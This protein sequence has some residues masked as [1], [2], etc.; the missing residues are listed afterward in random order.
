MGPNAREMEAAAVAVAL[1]AAANETAAACNGGRRG[2]GY[3]SLRTPTGIKK[4][5]E[6]VL[7]PREQWD[8]FLFKSVQ[9]DYSMPP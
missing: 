9:D 2:S 1:P 4:T 3:R 5:S 7:V 6:L 8:R